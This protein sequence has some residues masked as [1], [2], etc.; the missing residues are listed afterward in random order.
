MRL[1][2]RS[3]M[4][5]DH[6][7]D[8]WRTRGAC[9]GHDDPELWWPHVKP[10]CPPT[11]VVRRQHMQAEAMCRRCPVRERCEAMGR[12]EPDGIWGGTWPHERHPVRPEP[13]TQ[14]ATLRL[15]RHY[16]E[17]G[18]SDR[19]IADQLGW[20]TRRVRRLRHRH[21]V[22]A[23]GAARP[24]TPAEEATFR[25]MLADGRDD[26]QI[27][28]AVGRTPNAVRARR[29]RLVGTAVAR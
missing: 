28:G 2:D 17:S 24:W 18:M 13:L 4:A 15:I 7:G 11:D 5:L 19:Q 23:G 12:A 1:A 3:A 8:D 25:T 22:P 26:E 27:A 16:A 6:H 9:R 21:Q 20:L 29:R 10:G 14:P